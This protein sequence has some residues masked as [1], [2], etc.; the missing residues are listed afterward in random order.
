M[1]DAVT[2]NPIAV[3]YDCVNNA[4]ANRVEV[5]CDVLVMIQLIWILILMD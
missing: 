4:A 2:I 1:P 3:T 5:S